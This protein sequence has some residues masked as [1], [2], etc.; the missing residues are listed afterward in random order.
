MDQTVKIA[1][2]GNPNV[3]KSTFFNSLTGMKQHTGNWA[4]KTVQN[5]FGRF[6]NYE[7]IDLP[8]TYSLLSCSKEEEIARDYICFGESDYTIVV[9]DMSTLQKNLNLVL[10]VLEITK[11]AVVL[12]NIAD[13]AEKNGIDIDVK[14]LS[15]ILGVPVKKTSANKDKDLKQ[16]PKILTKNTNPYKVNY[17]DLEESILKIEN[18]LDKYNIK[19]HKRWLSLRLLENDL[20]FINSYALHTGINPMDFEEIK[21]VVQNER[22]TFPSASDLI[23]ESLIK[24]SEEIANAVTKTPVS[25]KESFLDF[26]LLGKYTAFPIMLVGF[27]IILWITVVGANYPSAM[28]SAFFNS[29]TEKI[30]VFLTHTGLPLFLKDLIVN[31]L[32]KV[33][34]WVISVMLPPMA[35]FF[36]L[37]AIL[38][39]AGILPRIAF[40]T[41]R[42]F[43]K[44]GACGKQCLC[45]C[46]GLGCNAV[47]IT[48][49]RIIDSPRER[50]IAILTN[51]FMPCNGR[52]PTIILLSSVFLAGGGIFTG[53]FLSALIILSV[54]VLGTVVTIINSKILSKTLLKGESSS[55][56][57]ELPRYRKPMFLKA[58]L[59]A[60]KNKVWFVLLRAI[61]V[62]AP[63]GVIIFLLSNIHIRDTSVLEH[64]SLFLD[65]PAKLIGLDGT[66]LLSFILGSPANEIVLPIAM[67]IY[68]NSTGLSDISDL[69]KISGIL[70]ANG[71]TLKTAIITIVFSLLHWPC[72]TSMITIYKE[73]KSKKWTF[74]GFLIPTINAVLICFVLN[75]IL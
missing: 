17:G 43:Q 21:T 12:L 75:L 63:A 11:N 51:N 9:C 40:N 61:S 27:L 53:S 2:A 41:D 35:I 42:F 25:F 65:T 20:G 30:N 67:M 24:K 49:A 5:A 46:M 16:I 8:G 48:G 69:N 28:L 1:L 4:G 71:W 7:L 29:L 50:L 19:K 66:I 45:M 13:Q 57:M 18:I 73:T 39:D 60:V 58:I 6:E 14:K 68:L 38:E 52:F 26:I 37:F 70:L 31:G 74:L 10:Q 32:F 72:T 59:Y 54:I 23:N 56:I 22:T 47:G 3:G 15:G 62:A 36:P 64:L 33:S 55:F 34:F 44:A